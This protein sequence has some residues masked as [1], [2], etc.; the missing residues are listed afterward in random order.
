METKHSAFIRARR[1]HIQDLSKT[2]Y[3]SPPHLEQGPVFPASFEPSALCPGFRQR[4]R[5]PR[6]QHPRPHRAH[7]TPTRTH[8]PTHT[9]TQPHPHAR[10]HA[11][12]TR[13]PTRTR[14]H[15][16]THTH[17][18]STH[19]GKHSQPASQAPSAH[20]RN[21]GTGT[22]ADNTLN[23]HRAHSMPTRTHARTHP[24]THNPIRTR[25]RMSYTHAH[26]HTRAL[27]H[28]H[29]HHPTQ[30]R[31]SPAYEPSA[32]CPGFQQRPSW[33]ARRQHP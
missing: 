26:S 9:H 23:P 12:H 1:D 32:L 16:H 29:S 21:S 25:A 6:R 17:T 3:L 19:R 13:T 2:K 15:T 11:I 18:H 5:H 14:T 33:R 22:H 7:S 31:T 24:H 27:T 20:G 4:R 30:G 10:A 8:A 28:T